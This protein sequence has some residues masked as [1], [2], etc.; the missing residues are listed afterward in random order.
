MPKTALIQGDGVKL[1]P[2]GNA[3]RCQVAAILQRF[4]ENFVM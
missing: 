3:K 2:T 4:I 1:M